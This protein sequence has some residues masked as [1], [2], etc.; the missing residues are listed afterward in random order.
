MGGQN[1]SLLSR[2]HLDHCID[3]IRQALMCAA[4]VSTGWLEWNEES[5]MNLAIM[6]TTHSCRRFDK[7]Q[8]WAKERKLV[9]WN[10][11]IRVE[12]PLRRREASIDGVHK[13]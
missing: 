5:K 6:S 1:M 9:A 10:A 8:E 12:D 11:K 3:Q 4:D 2:K 13:N 7:I